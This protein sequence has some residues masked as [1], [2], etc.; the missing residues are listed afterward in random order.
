MKISVADTLAVNDN[1]W[2]IFLFIPFD[3]N[4]VVAD[5]FCCLLI[6]GGFWL[7][8]G[9]L[10]HEPPLGAGEQNS[11]GT[12]LTKPMG[13]FARDVW[14]GGVMAMLD[15]GHFEAELYQMGDDLLH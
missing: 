1:F 11:I 5:E 9:I 8:V 3:K 6:Q 13:I 7:V 12:R 14:V 15:G 10:N 4:D 2:L